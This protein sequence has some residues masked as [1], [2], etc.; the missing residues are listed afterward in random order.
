MKSYF[1]GREGTSRD[2]AVKP[3]ISAQIGIPGLCGDGLKGVLLPQTLFAVAEDSRQTENA[4]R[5]HC[6]GAAASFR[7]AYGETKS[8]GG[9]IGFVLV[10]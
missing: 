6:R 5:P 3:G 9:W 4:K 7:R 1:E 2:H 8:F 10:L